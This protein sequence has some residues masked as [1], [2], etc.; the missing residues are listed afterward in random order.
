MENKKI[1]FKK[2]VSI[3]IIKNACGKFKRTS[4]IV[5]TEEA[6][7]NDDKFKINFYLN[8]NSHYKIIAQIND[9]YLYIYS[10]LAVDNLAKKSYSTMFDDFQRTDC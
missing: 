10:I 1:L 7:Q 9:L 6:S 3:S 2:I 4:K 5:L 8:L